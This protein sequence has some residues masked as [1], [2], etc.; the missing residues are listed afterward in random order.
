MKT[1]HPYTERPNLGRNGL[2]VIQLSNKALRSMEEPVV[3]FFHETYHHYRMA[4]YGNTGTEK[5]AEAFAQVMWRKISG[6]Q[7]TMPHTGRTTPC[8]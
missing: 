7:V 5:D 4:N 2:P 6:R 1:T 3:T 8:R